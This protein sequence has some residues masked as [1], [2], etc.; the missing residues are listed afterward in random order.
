MLYE[1][2]TPTEKGYCVMLDLGAN[3]EC[4]AVNLVEFAVMGVS[5]AKAI[6]GKERPTVGLLN[7]GVITSYSIHY[8]KLYE[9]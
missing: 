3:T 6:L 5:F 7:I 9:C 4:D 8:T 1:V 2:I